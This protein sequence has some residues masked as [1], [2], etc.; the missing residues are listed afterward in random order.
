MTDPRR[1]IVEVVRCSMRLM[2]SSDEVQITAFFRF[3]GT[4]QKRHSQQIPLD[5]LRVFTNEWLGL[6]HFKCQL[7]EHSSHIIIGLRGPEEPKQKSASHLFDFG[8]INRKVYVLTD[9][10]AGIEKKNRSWFGGR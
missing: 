9:S 4:L 5:S 10:G 8:I 1:F 7:F 6:A 3:S 2:L